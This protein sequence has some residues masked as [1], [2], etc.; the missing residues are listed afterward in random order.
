MRQEVLLMEGN[1]KIE[2]VVFDWAGTTVD[3]GSSAPSEVF[4]RVFRATGVQLT[5]EEINRPMGLEKKA[6]IREL[7]SCESGRSQWQNRYGRGWTEADVDDLYEKFEATLH[8]VV[9]ERSDPMDGVVETVDALRSAGLKIG[10]TTGYNDWMMEQVLPRAAAGGYTPDCVVTPDATGIGRPSPFML[11]ECMRRMKIYPPCHVVKVGD[12]T[13]DMREGKNAGA[14]S[15]GILTGSNLLGL[16]PE[17]YRTMPAEE[18]ARR[19][20]QAAARYR[21]AGADL[22]IDTIRELP[23]AIETLNRR[24]ADTEEASL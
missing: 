16:T 4:D 2:M 10:S 21:D 3:Y 15:I 6:H 18:L 20:E 19:K 7:L 17:E 5:K 1:H 13:V 11:F 8:E 14:F 9:A 24:L 22:V 23:E 12:T